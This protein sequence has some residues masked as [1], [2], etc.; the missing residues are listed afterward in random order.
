MKKVLHIIASPR[1]QASRTLKISQ[2]LIEKIKAKYGDID[3]DNLDLFQEELPQMNVTRVK[4]KYTLMSGEPLEG[5]SLA[6][7]DQIKAHIARFLSA[8]LIIISTPMWN[9]SIPYVLKHYIDII[10]QPG[11]MFKY[12]DKGPVGLAG[13]RELFIV[14][15]RGGDYSKG[16]PAESF[17][18]LEPYLSQVFTFI[19]FSDIRHISAQPMD[20]A[21]EEVREAKISQAVSLAESIVDKLN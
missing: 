6:A 17:D 14:S 1:G 16:S 9:F 10:V 13:G 15:T 12:T 18:R 3:L 5:E 4:G 21:T 8:D 20:A 11:F 19:G 7:W 2:R